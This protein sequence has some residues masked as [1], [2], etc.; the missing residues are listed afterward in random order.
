MAQHRPA[1]SSIPYIFDHLYELHLVYAWLHKVASSTVFQDSRPFYVTNIISQWQP[2]AVRS[3]SKYQI[4]HL[5][6]PFRATELTP[7]KTTHVLP[8]YCHLK[9]W[10][11]PFPQR[12]TPRL[13]AKV[14]DV[15]H[16]VNDLDE[17]V[18]CKMLRMYCSRCLTLRPMVLNHSQKMRKCC[19]SSSFQMAQFWRQEKTLA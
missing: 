11:S 15:C 1:H 12:P 4:C 13:P 9:C 16:F 17:A 18:C 5:L 14:C 2:D 3:K 10:P 8:P 6:V 19:Q 7:L